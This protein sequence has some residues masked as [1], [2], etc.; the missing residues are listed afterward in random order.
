[1]ADTYGLLVNAGGLVH[2][3]NVGRRRTGVTTHTF[4]LSLSVSLFLSLG[5]CDKICVFRLAVGGRHQPLSGCLCAVLQSLRTNILYIRVLFINRGL[6]ISFAGR[7][8]RCVTEQTQ[9]GELN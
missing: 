1:M 2:F 5:L 6:A 7:R 4:S 8:L 3:T 9:V